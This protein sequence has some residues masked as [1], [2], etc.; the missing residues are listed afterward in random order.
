MEE[1]AKK[2]PVAAG[3]AVVIG[4]SIYA[5]LPSIET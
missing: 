5:L 1:N 2:G 4:G 3:E